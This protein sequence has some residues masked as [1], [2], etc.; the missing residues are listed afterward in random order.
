MT[1]KTLL[2]TLLALAFLVLAVDYLFVHVL[3]PHKR[4][5]FLERLFDAPQ[6]FSAASPLP[7][8]LKTEFAP[9]ER[10]G[11][12]HFK[13]SLEECVSDPELKASP[14]PKDLLV[15]LEKKYGIKSRTQN[16]E[17]IHFITSDQQ[18]RRLEITTAITDQGPS[19]ELH[20]FTVDAQGMPS[21]V[22]IDPSM[23]ANPTPQVLAALIKDGVI[24]YHQIKET[25]MFNHEIPVMVDWIN[26]DTKDFQIVT[27]KKTMSCQYLDCTCK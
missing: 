18:E 7:P 1:R 16:H 23:M 9:A 24:K 4:K 8:G 3:F 14:S 12:D 21:P 10:V 11:P 17:N 25:I 13:K 6:N 2:S 19:H 26:D 27:D 5:L 15:Q 20:L 22:D